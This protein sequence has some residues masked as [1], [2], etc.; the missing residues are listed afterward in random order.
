MFPH[1]TAALSPK[2]DALDKIHRQSALTAGG[3]DG[4]TRRFLAGWPVFK[5]PD[6]TFSRSGE[7]I[8][9]P[10]HPFKKWNCPKRTKTSVSFSF[11]SVLISF[12]SHKSCAAP[13]CLHSVQWNNISVSAS[14]TLK[15]QASVWKYLKRQLFL[16]HLGSWHDLGLT[17]RQVDCLCVWPAV[18]ANS[19]LL[20]LWELKVLNLVLSVS[21]GCSEDCQQHTHTVCPSFLLQAEIMMMGHLLQFC[22]LWFC[23]YVD[24]HD[25]SSCLWII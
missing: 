25:D 16:A 19:C 9:N 6:E 24:N 18:P 21:R 2:Y 5:K 11:I 1:N 20:C 23:F 8:T 13:C 7:Q 17:L 15:C 22:R 4:V 14:S 3:E 10:K 12:R